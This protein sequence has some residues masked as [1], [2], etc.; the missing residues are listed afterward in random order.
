MGDLV[1]QLGASNL[2]S[3]DTMS[4]SDPFMVLFKVNKKKFRFIIT[5]T[6]RGQWCVP[7]LGADRG[8]QGHP[9][10]EVE[11]AEGGGEPAAHAQEQ[12]DYHEVK[13]CSYVYVLIFL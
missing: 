12:G 4:K 1:L 6:E 11:G 7:L 2:P 10:P 9:G 5:T 13:T 8:G 3:A